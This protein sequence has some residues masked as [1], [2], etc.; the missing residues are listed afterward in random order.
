[1]T[2]LTVERLRELL[3]YDPDTGLFTWRVR[4]RNSVKFG[5]VAGCF[6]S[7]G[8]W[9]IQIDGRKHRAHR[10]A[11]LYVTGEWPTSD[12]DHING[13]RD[14]NRIANLRAATRSE[15]GQ[16]QREPQSHN[17]VGYL[18]VHSHQGKFRAI[19]ILDG[20]KKH[21]GCFPTPE[22]AHAAYLEAKRRLHPFGTI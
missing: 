11:W 7:T 6:S 3:D 13:I 2:D 12:L 19:I 18:G 17:K 22:A 16:N 10:L 8:Y 14:D 20:K 4:T 9:Q 5:D 15:N 1:M 21:I